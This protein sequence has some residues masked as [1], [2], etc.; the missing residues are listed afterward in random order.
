MAG[1]R[2]LGC[3]RTFGCMQLDARKKMTNKKSAA[4]EKME[5]DLRRWNQ[6]SEGACWLRAA[7]S[8]ETERRLI[9]KEFDSVESRPRFEIPG[10][11]NRDANFHMEAYAD[12]PTV[13][14]RG[15]KYQTF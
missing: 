13:T 11:A 5:S 3:Q 14:P 9:Q 4:R 8:Q 2:V 1:S 12:C 6:T 10:A 7:Q 15:S